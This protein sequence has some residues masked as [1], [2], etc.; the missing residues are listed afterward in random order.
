MN[1]SR[2]PGKL[3][4]VALVTG[5]LLMMQLPLRAQTNFLP[6]FAV[7]TAGDT[8]RGFINYRETNNTP[9]TF[10]FKSQEA[11]NHT[12]EYSTGD[13]QYVEIIGIEAYRRY[14]GLI[15]MNPTDLK[16]HAYLDI[17]PQEVTVFL[18]LHVEGGQ[19]DLLSYTDQLKTRYFIQ[20]K[21]GS[22]PQ[23]LYFSRSFTPG[24]NTQ[25][26]EQKGYVGQLQFLASK[27]KPDDARLQKS[28]ASAQYAVSYLEKIILGINESGYGNAPSVKS[29]K[30]ATRF[31]AGAA[32][33]ASSIKVERSSALENADSNPISIMPIL[34]VGFDIF[35][36]KH[37]QKFY[38]RMELAATAANYQIQ[39]KLHSQYGYYNAYSYKVNQRVLSLSPQVIYTTFSRDN[40][41]H[42][43]GLA[44]SVNLA[45][46]PENTYQ[47]EY[48]YD[49][50][51]RRADPSIN[52]ITLS[53]MNF[54]YSYGIRTGV[55]IGSKF[56]IAAAYN[57][58][59]LL[60][61]FVTTRIR[62][63]SFS[64]GLNYMIRQ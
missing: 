43:L 33:N 58:P 11:S 47:I 27:L 56:V 16:R 28:I 48:Y 22:K 57:P 12:T 39:N 32:L 37:T 25:V 10:T 23:E 49:D 17:A 21:N 45:G 19:V 34:A 41:K 15:T 24:S 7:T 30:P 64:L 26:M 55:I 40:F 61:Q 38:L 42:Y 1:L 20:E 52:D 29:L 35:R 2:F 54:Y 50:G 31:Y 60:S 6:G 14:S 46:Y 44:A 5:L 3:Q 8:L 13:I 53:L 9:A 59:A 18:K 51:T 36:N 63:Q 4:Q 62:Q